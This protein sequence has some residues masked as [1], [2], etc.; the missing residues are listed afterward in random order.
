MAVRDRIK[1]GLIQLADAEKDIYSGAGWQIARFENETLVELF[2]PKNTPF[3]TDTKAMT[4]EAINDAMIWMSSTDGEHW[5]VKCASNELHEP[6][7]ITPTDAN[8]FEKMARE[9]GAALGGN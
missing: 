9:F 3:N 7:R 2:D 6:L 1:E 4:T 5:L 8:V